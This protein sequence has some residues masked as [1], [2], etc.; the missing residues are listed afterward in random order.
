MPSGE[1]WLPD[2]ELARPA[3]V[4]AKRF[5]LRWDLYPVQLDDG[6]YI[7]VHEPLS[8]S[9]LYAHLRG[10]VTLGTYLLNQ[11]SMVRFVVLD[12][13]AEGG[14]DYVVA[15][16]ARLVQ[17]GIPAYLEKS[18]RGGHIW[19]FFAKP[20][21][22]FIARNFAKELLEAN[23]LNGF[24]IYP[25]QD[26][27]GKGLGSLI[28]LPFGVHRLTGRRYGFYASTGEPLGN[29]FREQIAS[30]QSPHFVSRDMLKPHE[31]TSPPSTDEAVQK[32]LREPTGLVSER[33]KA[34][35]SV[36]EFISQY[37]DLKRTETGAVGLCPFHNDQH[38]SFGVND[39]EN[40]WH[41]F[42]G[43]GGGSLIDFWSLWR[44]KKGLES[45]F[46]STITDLAE[47]L[48]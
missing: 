36:L 13:D 12:N 40:Y 33:I 46:I 37:V 10:E 5:F 26:L 32:R 2:E 47:L 7:C 17:K 44:K 22:G 30:L 16:G 20:I 14:W 23:K 15:C 35:V 1:R 48:L 41:C 6:R 9:H 34:Q 8:A 11:D 18:R 31:H 24:E 38:P 27:I 28:R 21:D 19:F 42:A 4:L 3:A 43:C 45:G 39:K 25:K 29:T